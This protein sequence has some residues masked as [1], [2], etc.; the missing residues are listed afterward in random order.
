MQYPNSQ[1][2]AKDEVGPV[3]QRCGSSSLR[4]KSA[5]AIE[6]LQHTKIWASPIDLP[7]H[8]PELKLSPVQNKKCFEPA[9][10]V[11]IKRKHRESASR[12]SSRSRNDMNVSSALAQDW[13]ELFNDDGL[14]SY[15]SST[16][17][18]ET[19]L[20]RSLSNSKISNLINPSPSSRDI[21]WEESLQNEDAINLMR[22]NSQHF[23]NALS[24]RETLSPR[25][26]MEELLALM[27]SPQEPYSLFA[28]RQFLVAEWLPK[29]NNDNRC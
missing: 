20:Q 26:K 8:D 4:L 22:T 17:F 15:P 2:A 7:Q 9:K 12:I 19:N 18:P 21:L 16:G 27:K 24:N 6:F 11:T 28:C 23:D 3:R 14:R 1:H 10:K 25:D 29:N 13:E 5:A